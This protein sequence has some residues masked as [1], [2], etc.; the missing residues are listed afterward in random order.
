MAFRP[1]PRFGPSALLVA[2]LFSGNVGQAEP[3]SSFELSWQ[4]PATCPSR[5]EVAREIG[6]LIGDAARA[7]AT[8][9]AFAEVTRHDE[10]GWRVHIRLQEG[11]HQSERSFDGP[12]CQAVTRV[13]ALIIALTIDPTAGSAP[14]PAPPRPVEKPPSSP[15]NAPPAGEAPLKWFLGAGPLFEQ[16]LLPRLGFG[17]EVSLGMRLPAFSAE[18]RGAASLSQPT[19]AT[20]AGAGGRFFL[21]AMGARVCARIVPGMAEIF[22]CAAGSL[23]R[24]QADGYGVTLPGSATATF[25]TL[26]LG[27]RVDFRLGVAPSIS[28]GA[29]ATHTF[30]EADFVLDNIGSVHRTPRWGV[31]ARLQFAWLF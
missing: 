25:G 7:R 12:S 16:R 20:S 8:V 3:A 5:D 18:L 13:A 27:P 9:R 29:E 15:P 30:S 24:L 23:D 14:E 28:L 31:S 22:G 6:R 10:E 11:T 26:A 4:A 17:V 19:D 1:N 21:A 2:I